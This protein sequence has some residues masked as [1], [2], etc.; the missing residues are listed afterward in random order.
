MK[1]FLIAGEASGDL[2]ASHLMRELRAADPEAQFRF[3]GGNRMAAVGGELLC[4]Y[5][6]LA[7]MGF[8]Q[9]ALHLPTILR[10]MKRCREAIDAWRPDAV[11]LVDYPGFN[12][13]MAKF[14]KQHALCPVF[15][16]IAPKIWAWKEHRIAAIRRHV[17][18]LF[19][20][21]PFEVDFFE[22][23]HRYPISYVGNPSVD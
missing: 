6:S 21:L 11:I 17:D 3:F 15:Y 10:G 12:L 4:H 20:I 5:E 23:K 1:Y 14:V 18:R 16:Y 22:G 13:K 7:Y 19:S 8:L 9:V 2:H